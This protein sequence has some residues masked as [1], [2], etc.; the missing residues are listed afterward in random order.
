MAEESIKGKIWDLLL[1]L[2]KI[3]SVNNHAMMRATLPLS[4]EFT[5]WFL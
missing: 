2:S 3:I 5:T 4:H 1:N